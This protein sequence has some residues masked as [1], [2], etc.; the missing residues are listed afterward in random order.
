M[1]LILQ[2]YDTPRLGELKTLNAAGPQLGFSWD[3]EAETDKN[4]NG[5]IGNLLWSPKGLSFVG[6]H[7]SPRGPCDR[8]RR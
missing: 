3:D 6:Y 5:G 8:S 7:H 4:T 1:N 2:F